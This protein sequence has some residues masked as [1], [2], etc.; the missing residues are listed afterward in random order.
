MPRAKA[1]ILFSGGLDSSTCLFLAKEQGFEPITLSINYS[2]RHDLEMVY[3][4]KMLEHVNV[5]ESVFLPFD[6]S[7]IGGSALTDPS[8]EV[9]RGGEGLES[10]TI[11]VT[12]VPARNLIFL[13]LASALAEVKN[14]QHIFIGINALDYSGYPD[15][16]SDF[17]FSFEE[18]CS[19]ATKIGREFGRIKIE[20]PL[21]NLKKSEIIKKGNAL[22]VPY[23]FTWSCYDPN[24]DQTPCLNCDSCILRKK[25]FAEAGLTDPLIKD[26]FS[27]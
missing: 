11:P 21:I 5:K 22:K 13:S 8:M 23:E 19:L 24:D 7:L 1:V 2:Q 10:N 15:C 17:I 14:I 18:T 9:P 20:T 26:I 25:G 16:R 4:R 12:Y 3:A 27:V 6:L